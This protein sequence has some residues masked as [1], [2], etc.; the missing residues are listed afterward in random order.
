MRSQ[1]W[2]ELKEGCSK[3]REHQE[4][5]PKGRRELARSR[6]RKWPSE[7]A[8]LTAA[9]TAGWGRVHTYV[10]AH[11]AV[12]PGA[13]PEAH[14]LS[15]LCLSLL[16]LESLELLTC[17]VIC[18]STPQGKEPTALFSLYF[19]LLRFGWNLCLPLGVWPLCSRRRKN[20][21]RRA[22]SEGGSQ[23]FWGKPSI[24]W[25]KARAGQQRQRKKGLNDCCQKV[26]GALVK[27]TPTTSS[28]ARVIGQI[29]WDTTHC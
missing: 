7:S 2:E 9:K 5:K 3:N 22:E 1:V 12:A 15:Y 25:R 28:L 27:G 13:F 21:G 29:G 11:A 20:W 8:R 18:I 24:F 10:F 16:F 23:L 17:L 4:Q 26:L 6:R 14:R 19:V